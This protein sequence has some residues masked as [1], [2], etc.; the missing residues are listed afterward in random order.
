MTPAC[1]RHE[2]QSH[3]DQAGH[4]KSQSSGAELLVGF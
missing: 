1:S 4:D 3:R 2:N